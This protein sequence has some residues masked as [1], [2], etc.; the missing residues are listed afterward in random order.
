MVKN[1]RIDVSAKDVRHQAMS[2]VLAY[3]QVLKERVSRLGVESN[4]TVRLPQATTA[5]HRAAVVKRK[6]RG[7]FREPEIETESL[8]ELQEE[9]SRT[10]LY[11]AP[12]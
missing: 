11:A 4:R 7:R 10:C 8:N 2:A 12:N 6:A 3:T 1:V 9:V 5:K